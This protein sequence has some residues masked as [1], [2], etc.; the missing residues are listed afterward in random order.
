MALRDNF[1]NF[2]PLSLVPQYVFGALCFALVVLGIPWQAF[3]QAPSGSVQSV[4]EQECSDKGPVAGVLCGRKVLE[5][6]GA[7]GR[8]IAQIFVHGLW[9]THPSVVE[10]ELRLIPGEVWTLQHHEDSRVR[11]CDVRI[12]RDVTFYLTQAPKNEVNVHVVLDERWAILPVI[13]ISG[14]G[15]AVAL[16]LGVR[17]ANFWGK[18]ITTRLQYENFAGEHGVRGWVWDRQFLGG[19]NHLYVEGS[20]TSRARLLFRRDGEV[21][22]AYDESRSGGLVRVRRELWQNFWVGGGVVLRLDRFGDDLLTQQQRELNR[23]LPA[24]PVPSNAFVSLAR[25]DVLL[26][27][28]YLHEFRFHG[29]RAWFSYEVSHGLLGSDL[30][31][32]RASLELQSAL[33][34]PWRSNLAARLWIAASNVTAIQELFYVG[35]FDRVRA[36]ADGQFRGSSA[37]SWNLEYRIPSID[38]RWF[39]LQ[40]VVF[41]DAGDAADSWADLVGSG[42]PPWSTG[43]GVRLS[44]P[45]IHRA[46]IRVDYGFAFGEQFAHGITFGTQQ[47]F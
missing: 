10:A 38:T 45:K 19:P 6:K 25:L 28:V 1:T 14:G 13:K 39:V 17:D 31:F 47:F 9:R 26:G 34:L 12:F 27:R 46:R 18:Y 7:K 22:G 43:V 11:L 33:L 40:H 44:S 32:H 23:A 36:F 35:G 37:W 3:A 4:S 21:E 8:N 29:N 42:L 24:S 41:L 15:N 2:P 16:A 5:P 20:S 30:D